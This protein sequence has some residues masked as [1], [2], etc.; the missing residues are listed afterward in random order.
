MIEKTPG[1]CLIEKLRSII[2]MEADYN[3]NNKEVFGVNMMENV[4]RRGLMM[5]EIFSEV[6]KTAEDGE[7]AKVLFYD[8]IRQCQLLAAI[9]SGDATNCYDSIAHAIISLIFQV[10]GVPAEGVT[11]MLLAIQEMKYFL[12]LEN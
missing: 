3:A 4:C 8:I 2:L 10:C 9:S 11:A 12:R 5:E 7:L 6:G 1:C